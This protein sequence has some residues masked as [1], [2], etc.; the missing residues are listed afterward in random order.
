[1]RRKLRERDFWIATAFLVFMFFLSGIW[2]WELQIW[3]IIFAL[4]CVADTGSAYGCFLKDGRSV[5]NA[6]NWI[7]RRF[8]AEFGS[9]MGIV[10]GAAFFSLIII[11]AVAYFF[12]HL[13]PTLGKLLFFIASVYKTEVAVC[14]LAYVWFNKKLPVIFAPEPM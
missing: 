6:S 2:R 4:A 14:N 10:W 12:E 7:I 11:G 5:K 8:A 1:M 13:V 3:F 9:K